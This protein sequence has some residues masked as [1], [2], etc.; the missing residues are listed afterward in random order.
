MVEPDTFH[1][2]NKIGC[3][4][5]AGWTSKATDTHS[6]YVTQCFSTTTMVVLT[7]LTVTLYVYFLSCFI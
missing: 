6:E 3:M 1:F 4:R 7:R 5:F 2:D